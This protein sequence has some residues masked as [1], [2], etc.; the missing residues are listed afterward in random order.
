MGSSVLPSAKTI[1]MSIKVCGI[2]AHGFLSNCLEFPFCGG[3]G[4]A[5]RQFYES[6]RG[7]SR[8]ADN[9]YALHKSE[10]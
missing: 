2:E 9:G 4:N 3:S 7:I 8:R 6:G 10:I 5:R 1:T